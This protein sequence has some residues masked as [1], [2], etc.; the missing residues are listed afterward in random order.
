MAEAVLWKASDMRRVCENLVPDV[1]TYNSVINAYLNHQDQS[2]ALDRILEIV[3]YM[4]ENRED[5]PKIAPDCFTQHCLLRAWDKSDRPDAAI[6]VVN[7][8]ETMHRMWEAGDD[9]IKPANAYYNMAINKIAKSNNAV[10]PQ[11]AL[12]ILRL[13]Q[14]SQFCNPDIISYTSVIEC[15]SK[16][17]Q[18]DAAK[19]SVNL[20]EEVREIYLKLKDPTI[21]PNSRTYTMVIL[22]L[23]KNPTLQSVVKSR[24]LLD[25][26]HDRYAATHDPNLRPSAYPY[27]Y[28]LNSAASCV[29]DARDK[30]DAFQIAATTFNELRKSDFAEPDSYTY[31]FWF[32]ACISLL[33]ESEF[34]EKAIS[35]SFECAKKEGLVS[36]E[37]LRRLR[38]LGNMTDLE[39]NTT[40][41]HLPPSWSRNVR[42]PTRTKEVLVG[43]RAVSE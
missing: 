32:K 23:T 12:G 15:F 34:K 24:E 21:M 17:K 11:R 28:V 25:E 9:S 35:C 5:Q 14:T 39:P 8:I 31:C 43:R 1:V 26:L 3:S 18:S 29:G 38:G 10:H 33:P 30:L 20:F 37:V 6:Y 22:S 7:T 13:L 16:S 36:D 4:E 27:N 40:L 42:G 19:T 2:F 41:R